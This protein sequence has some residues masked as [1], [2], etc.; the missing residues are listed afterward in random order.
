MRILADYV[1]SGYVHP[2]V[3]L[4]AL[5]HGDDDDGGDEWHVINLPFLAS[6]REG[7]KEN[8]IISFLHPPSFYS[9]S[10]LPLPAP[11]P[12]PPLSASL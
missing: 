8:I 4:I 9:P 5:N 1:T 6:K 2:L 7:K 12:V 11:S 3:S 10:H